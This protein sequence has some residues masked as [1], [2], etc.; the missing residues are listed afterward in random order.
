VHGGRHLTVRGGASRSG[1]VGTRSGILPRGARAA[2]GPPQPH[3]GGVAG[4]WPRRRG[5][6]AATAAW[7]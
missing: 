4:T 1:A 2:L 3:R 5:A 7:P 6:E